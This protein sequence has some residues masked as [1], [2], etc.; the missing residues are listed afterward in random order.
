MALGSTRPPYN[1]LTTIFSPPSDCFANFPSTWNGCAG[2]TCYLA[3]NPTCLPEQ[4]SQSVAT[5]TDTSYYLGRHY[6]A[7]IYAVIS[8]GYSPGVMALGYWHETMSI[9]ET[10]SL[11]QVDQRT[12]VTACPSRWSGCDQAC[13]SAASGTYVTFEMTT[14]GP[15]NTITTYP[16]LVTGTFTAAIPQIRVTWESSDLVSFTPASAPILAPSKIAAFYSSVAPPS[17]K[18]KN[19]GG[20]GGSRVVSTSTKLPGPTATKTTRPNA[21]SG[22]GKIDRHGLSRG[23]QAGIGVGVALPVVLIILLGI[24]LSKRRRRK[25]GAPKRAESKRP[26]VD[27]KAELDATTEQRKTDT[28]RELADREPQE[29]RAEPSK[30]PPIP[31]A[32]KPRYISGCSVELDGGFEGHESAEPPSPEH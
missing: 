6:T 1:P 26:Y 7:S 30:A 17:A 29:L 15:D 31:Y 21:S 2:G 4:D 18:P 22:N 20:G 25:L 14:S 27:S 28:T 9:W 12:I 3:V 8:A 32:S 16:T 23:A 19:V 11:A 5:I 13:C 24:F 10:V